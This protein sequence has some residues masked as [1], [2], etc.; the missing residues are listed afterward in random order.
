MSLAPADLRQ[1][2]DRLGPMEDLEPPTVTLVNGPGQ[3]RFE[4]SSPFRRHVPVMHGDPEALGLDLHP[5]DGRGAPGQRLAEGTNHRL[6]GDGLGVAEDD[7]RAV[8]DETVTAGIHGTRHGDPLGHVAQVA[9]RNHGEAD[10][11]GPGEDAEV[12]LDLQGEP[13]VPGVRD[14]RGQG[15]VIVRHEQQ[16]TAAAQPGSEPV[17]EHFAVFARVYLHAR[18]RR[19]GH[20]SEGSSRLSFKRLI[21]NNLERT[22]SLLSVI[23][24]G[25]YYSPHGKLYRR[26][27]SASLAR[28]RAHRPCP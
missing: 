20:A 13:G 17:Y 24:G 11:R 5:L 1:D 4:G 3:L 7:A 27:A 9:A 16:T 23:R 21:G 19:N 10:T 12:M 6:L 22:R 25:K 15:P 18:P 8:D 2:L 14:V 26:I 28:P